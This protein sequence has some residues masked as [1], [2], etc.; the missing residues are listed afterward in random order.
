MKHPPAALL[1]ATMD[2]KGQEALFIAEC[3]KKE[4]IPVK[5][6]DAGIR[7]K[8]HAPVDITREEVAAAAGNTLAEV[9]NIGHEG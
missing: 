4:N 9:Q 3:L 5:I 6:L 7:G 8:C 2:T 1:V